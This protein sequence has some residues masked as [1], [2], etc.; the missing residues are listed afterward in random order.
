MDPLQAALEWVKKYQALKPD[1]IRR[2]IP[3]EVTRREFRAELR[4]VHKLRVREVKARG[5]KPRKGSA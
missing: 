4:R 1:E 5:P 2:R 3:K